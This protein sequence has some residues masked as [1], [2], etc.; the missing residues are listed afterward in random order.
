VGTIFAGFS[1]FACCLCSTGYSLTTSRVGY[2]RLLPSAHVGLWQTRQQ[3]CDQEC[4]CMFQMGNRFLHTSV[5]VCCQQRLT[6]LL[7]LLLLLLEH[8]G[9]L[10]VS[11]TCRAAASAWQGHRSCCGAMPAVEARQALLHRRGST[12]YRWTGASASRCAIL[13]T[14]LYKPVCAHLYVRLAH[15][16]QCL[17][18]GEAVTVLL[19]WCD[20]SGGSEAAAVSPAAGIN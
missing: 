6:A 1:C 8:A 16:M 3:R 17:C 13:Q 4:V 14:Y 18:S 5:A 10:R 20:V 12:R 15:I 2:L 11:Q 19:L 9:T 7:L